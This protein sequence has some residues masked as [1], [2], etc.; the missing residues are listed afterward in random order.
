[1]HLWWSRKPLTACRAVIFCSLV[2][3]PGEEGVPAELLRQIDA[4]PEPSPPL[5]DWDVMDRAERRRQKLFNFIETLVHWDSTTDE[6]VIGTARE[7]ILAATDGNPP[8]LLDP[9]CGGGSIP[10]EAQ[11]LGLEVH[12]SDLNPVAVL[13]TKALIELPPR[14]AGMPPVNPNARAEIGSDAEWRGAAGLAEDVRWYGEWVRQRAWERIGHL[15]PEGPNGETVIAWLWARTVTCPNPVCGV[16]MPLVHSF[17]LSKKRGDWAEPLFEGRAL[18]FEVRDSGAPSLKGTVSRKGAICAACKTPVPFKYIREHAQRVGLGACLM[19]VA[20]RTSQG[21][22]FRSASAEDVSHADTLAP[23]DAPSAELPYNPRNFQT[24]IYGMTTYDDLFTARQLTALTAFSDLVKEVRELVQEHAAETI[25]VPDQTR[26]DQTRPDQT[27]P[28]RGRD[29]YVPGLGTRQVDR[30][31]IHAIDLGRSGR[32]RANR[33]HRSRP[34]D[35]LELRRSELFL[36]H[37]RQLGCGDRRD[38]ERAGASVA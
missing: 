9:F 25:I 11:R 2:D 1:M 34:S 16:A 38:C 37:R 36:R 4:L 12:G 33:L 5:A 18:R 3:D 27:R 30:A 23:N 10:L 32:H 22:T 31:W 17:W 20:E 8:P 24:P 29:L 6:G 15:Y 7:L 19:A 28:V 35:V 26:P 13:I 21:K 14:F